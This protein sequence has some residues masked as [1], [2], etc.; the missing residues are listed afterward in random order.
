MFIIGVTGGFASGKTA[1]SRMLARLGA[2]VIDADRI[3]HQ[4]LTPNRLPWKKIVEYFGNSI[5]NR[6]GTINRK[7]LSTIVFAEKKAL[8]K[9]SQIVHPEV[10]EKIKL[11]VEQIKKDEPD[12]VVVIDAPLLIEAGFRREVDKL[13]AVKASVDKQIERAAKKWGLSVTQIRRRLEAQMPLEF[14]A[15]MADYVIDNSGTLKQTRLQVE[16]IWREIR[17]KQK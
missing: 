4:A 8:R 10:F 13:I 15:R 1:V 9:L 16:K 2:K 17:R 12:S 7:R 6:D 3:G 14:K 5:L 11:M